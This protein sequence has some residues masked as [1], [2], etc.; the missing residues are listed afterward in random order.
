M[1]ELSAS[2]TIAVGQWGTASSETCVW[3]RERKEWSLYNRES[4][5]RVGTARRRTLF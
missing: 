5:S 3:R 2:V 4:V 1:A